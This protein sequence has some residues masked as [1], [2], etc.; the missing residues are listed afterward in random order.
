ELADAAQQEVDAG[1]KGRPIEGGIE[2]GGNAEGGGNDGIDAGGEVHFLA[3]VEARHASALIFLT[4]AAQVEAELPR[5]CALEVSEV[6]DGLPRAYDA[7]VT[8]VILKRVIHRRAGDG[9]LVQRRRLAEDGVVAI[10]A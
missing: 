7:L 1:L 9:D 5:V 4:D 2:I 3:G 6:I 10:F 8:E